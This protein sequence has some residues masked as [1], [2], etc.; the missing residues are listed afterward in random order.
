MWVITLQCHFQSYF[1]PLLMCEGRGHWKCLWKMF[2][3]GSK[4]Q[5]GRVDSSTFQKD[6]EG[7]EYEFT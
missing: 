7:H 4:R 5:K 2:R 1:P 6:D 3:Q